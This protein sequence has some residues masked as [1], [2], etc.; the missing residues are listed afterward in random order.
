MANFNTEN[1]TGS[2]LTEEGDRKYSGVFTMK[3]EDAEITIGGQIYG[4]GER[5]F[6]AFTDID[7]NPSL[8]SNAYPRT[9][10]M[11]RTYTKKIGSTTVAEPAYEDNSSPTYYT[12]N[13][14]GRRPGYGLKNYLDGGKPYV[15]TYRVNEDGDASVFDTA[16]TQRFGTET[17][18]V[19]VSADGTQKFNAPVGEVRAGETVTVRF[20]TA[21]RNTNADSWNLVPNSLAFDAYTEQGTFYTNTFERQTFKM[22]TSGSVTYDLDNGGTITIKCVAYGLSNEFSN[23]SESE[24][25]HP[26]RFRDGYMFSTTPLGGYGT[27]AS[28]WLYSFNPN[29]PNFNGVVK[30][31][32]WYAYEVTVSGCYHDF[33]MVQYSNAGAH[34]NAILDFSGTAT[35]EAVILNPDIDKDG[36]ADESPM[37]SDMKGRSYTYRTQDNKTQPGGKYYALEMPFTFRSYMVPNS[38]PV[39]LG[40]AVRRGYSPPSVTSSNAAVTIGAQ[41]YN[42]TTG[43]YEYTI[44][45][46]GTDGNNPPTT[47]TVKSQPVEFRAQFYDNGNINTGQIVYL[48]YGESQSRNYIIVPTGT[49]LERYPNLD[50]YEAW[51]V[52]TN[53]GTERYDTL[54]LKTPDGSTEWHAGDI[55]N[56]DAI[57]DQALA[58]GD[59]LKSSREFYRLEIRPIENT[60]GNPMLQGQ[61]QIKKQTGAN[62]GADYQSDAF[63]DI[64]TGTVQALQGSEVVIVGYRDQIFD[65]ISNKHFK[66]GLRSTTSGTLNQQDDVVAELY[67]LS[68]AEVSVDDSAIRDSY[69]DKTSGTGT[70]AQVDAWN[71]AQENQLYTSVSGESNVVDLSG[72]FA[73]LSA[74]TGPGQIS[75]FQIQYTDSSDASRTYS[76]SGTDS[77]DLSGLTGEVWDA[78]FGEAGKNRGTV[79]LVPVYG[80]QEITSTDE[81]NILKEG[82][83]VTTYTY[84]SPEP[85]VQNGSFKITGT[86]GFSG[87]ADALD[88]VQF[89]VTK[90]RKGWDDADPAQPDPSSDSSSVI[91]YGTIQKEADGSL[92]TVLEGGTYFENN[93]QKLEA[94]EAEEGKDVSTKGDTFT[95]AFAVKDN[96]GSISYQWDQDA[97]YGVHAWSDGNTDA[98]DSGQLRDAGSSLTSEPNRTNL[99]KELFLDD[100]RDIPGETHTVTV[101]P[102]KVSTAGGDAITQI[103]SPEAKLIYSET[104]F[105]LTADFGID[106]NYPQSL[107][108]G[109]D[110]PDESKVHTAVYKADPGETTAN[111]WVFEGEILNDGQ[112][113]G[114][115]EDKVD[116]GSVEMKVESD[117]AKSDDTVTA[118]YDFTDVVTGGAHTITKEW[119]DGAVYY[120]VAWNSSNEAGSD[121]TESN[122]NPA[123]GDSR[124]KAPSVSTE[125]EMS[126][127]MYSQEGLMYPGEENQQAGGE[128]PPVTPVETKV[129]M[130]ADGKYSLEAAFYMKGDV[131]E[132]ADKTAY[133]T[134]YAQEPRGSNSNKWGLTEKGVID[135]GN[136][137]ITQRVHEA[138]TNVIY[139]GRF[140]GP[141]PDATTVTVTK[142]E[143]GEDVFTKIVLKF[144]GISE[145]GI[146][147]MTYRFYMWNAGNGD[148]TQNSVSWLYD[149]TEALEAAGALPKTDYPC[150]AEQ[151]YVIPR[152]YSEGTESGALK[153]ENQ[154]KGKMFY[155][156]D[157]I[158][159]SGTFATAGN[160]IISVNDLL[161]NSKFAGELHVALYKQNPGENQY[162]RFAM[163]NT[164]GKGQL[165]GEEVDKA[166]TVAQ[167]TIEVDSANSDNFTVTFTKTDT[168]QQWDDGAQY[169]IYAWTES[170]VT[171]SLPA[172]FGRSGLGQIALSEEQINGITTLPSVETL[173]TAVLGTEVESIIHYPKQITMLDNVNPADKHIYSANQKIT[174]TPVRDDD[175]N[176]AEIPD[177]DP[178]VDVVI[179]EIRDARS[180]DA[181]EIS[182]N[183]GGS[184]ETIKLTCFIGEIDPPLTGTQISTDGKVGTLNFTSPTELLLY[185]RSQNEPNVADGA[186]FT[187]TIHFTFSKSAAGN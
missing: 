152:I 28:P 47:I 62:S 19:A 120:I 117:G 110:A 52:E 29:N 112:G 92:S 142:S 13:G 6:T 173:T 147:P 141:D 22:P 75:G 93:R 34:R 170:N 113:G 20:E 63:E 148:K 165:T 118:A 8:L 99:T 59:F 42:K 49:V 115:S 64:E 1:V 78:L 71:T 140:D 183:T 163:L 150:N 159:I 85:G 3:D 69:T 4:T 79:T 72:I 172:N 43:A 51:L 130:E 77:L 181:I 23:P 123:N 176:P 105:T 132:S 156:G 177:P 154:T 40:L 180:T 134:V 169:R 35:S 37:A 27:A 73:I 31:M 175:G 16:V 65:E 58:E 30:D 151:L 146:S 57:Y 119:E 136:Q 153:I 48:G 143:A 124:T 66:L 89:A 155:E 127:I 101:L 7:V 174:I 76:I 9:I 83:A 97:V 2:G 168:T 98:P 149:N 164:D 11:S 55:I 44:G 108:I 104:D 15:H 10:G 25:R 121:F 114:S 90:Q 80:S 50:H 186:P 88:G 166:A 36:N 122:L 56:Y 125:L 179:Q 131:N 33:K 187:G 70:A 38:G 18:E 87:D 26:R 144:T 68:A 100:T 84:G 167:A 67:Y 129:Y 178:G 107:Q 135:L 86:F 12:P 61:Y 111:G 81:N 14:G 39:K 60:S 161:N 158:K 5:W 160:S 82:T 94:A 21:I 133:Y 96:G 91:G 17:Q 24:R 109:P 74:D 171:D 157:D 45:L 102:K 138:Q 116:A 185:F 95:I 137:S 182:R 54:Q 128:Q 41:T 162:R 184:E 126:K 145:V 46:T 139:Y 103:P 106:P 53:G 32:K